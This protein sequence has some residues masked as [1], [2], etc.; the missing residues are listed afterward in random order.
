MKSI[1]L[2]KLLSMDDVSKEL[3][4]SKNL[5]FYLTNSPDMQ[6]KHFTIP[7]KNGT[8]RDIYSPSRTLRIVQ[9][10]IL[11]SILYKISPSDRAMAFIRHSPN[12]VHRGCKANAAYHG[13]SLFGLHIDIIDF[14]SHIGSWKVFKLF[15]SLG[16]NNSI[17]MILTNLCTLNRCLPQGG[18]T[19]P[20]LS[21]LVFVDIDDRIAELC[22]QYGIRYSRYADD[23]YFSC[24]NES[25]L[26][27]VHEKLG[28][29]CMTMDSPRISERQNAILI[30][31][32]YV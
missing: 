4:L 3:R 16:Y 8:E 13:G 14:Y 12:N 26:K 28:K 17:A 7:K 1:N 32:A 29:Y 6:Y 23:M 11:E 25:D 9:K 2:P 27:Q 5:L 19:S 30:Q 20:T 31:V 18:I 21:N 24:N 15:Q 22:D 10:W